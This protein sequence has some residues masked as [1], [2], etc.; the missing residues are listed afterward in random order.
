VTTVSRDTQVVVVGAGIG[1]LT[2]A[3]ALRRAGLEVSVL[4]RHAEIRPAGSGIMLWGDALD[5]LDRLGVGEAVQA[6]AGIVDRSEL[7]DPDGR[8]IE[9]LWIGSFLQ[10]DPRARPPVCIHRAT[11]HHV[12]VDALGRQ[13]VRLGAPC[14]TLSIEAAGVRV[15]VEGA[16]PVRADV[17]VGA[18]GIHSTVRTHLFPDVIPR[19]DGQTIFRGVA[20][21]GPDVAD[22]V[23]LV[24]IGDGCRFGWEPMGD[25]SVYWFGGRFQPESQPDH[26][27]GH[28]PDLLA[29]FGDWAPP[30]PQLIQRTAGTDILRNDVYVLDPLSEWGRGSVT[31][32]GDA[33]HAIAPHIG[34]G[35]C[36]AIDDAEALA[37]AL[38]A[39]PV[40]GSLRGYEA[41]R[42]DAVRPLL[43]RAA[44]LRKGL[45]SGTLTK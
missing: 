38:R 20:G 42:Q 43:D 3:I 44:E 25:G 33:A 6:N 19:Y 23:A 15:E 13:R 27:G 11:L 26:E 12:L 18:D 8:P 21:P 37:D 41:R 39:G 4:E 28:K 9:G 29:T 17:L 36:V 32:L 10:K 45:E 7:R 5:A 2:C 31:L 35:A 30:V 14:S 24:A 34:Q 22:G 1:G 40:E 16:A